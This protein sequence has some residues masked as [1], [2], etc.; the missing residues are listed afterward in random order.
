MGDKRQMGREG[1]N[2]TTMI[3][4]WNNR[5]YIYKEHMILQKIQNIKLLSMVELFFSALFCIFLVLN[6]ACSFLQVGLRGGTP[7]GAG[8]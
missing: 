4:Q 1:G 3:E 2:K 5:Q 8:C 6:T 7:G